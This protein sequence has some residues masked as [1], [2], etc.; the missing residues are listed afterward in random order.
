M[1]VL[2][3]ESLRK[4]IL[5]NKVVED[6]ED[7]DKQL[8][9]NGIDFRLAAILEVKEAGELRIN[10]EEGKLPAFGEVFVLKGYED[11]VKGTKADKVT[12]LEK[13]NLI[14]IKK[15]KP[16]LFITCEK[17]NTPTDIHT[18][19]EARSSLFRLTSLVL[20]T[21]FGEAGYKGRLTFMGFSLL[22]TKIDLGIRF[23][24][25]LFNTLDG[26]AHY[27]GQE[28]TNYQHGKII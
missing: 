16:Y 4:Q 6:Y 18:A 13:G 8:T 17:L 15:Q 28:E 10:K 26:H 23:A 27:E 1:S 11:V 19:I 22:D 3:K 24:Q 12:V 9:A 2:S 7:L 5:E 14:E 20:E 21:A 25:I